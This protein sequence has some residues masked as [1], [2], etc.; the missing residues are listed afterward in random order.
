MPPRRLTLPAVATLALVSL[1]LGALAAFAD[2]RRPAAGNALAHARTALVPQRTRLVAPKAVTRA[3]RASRPSLVTT[4]APM[5]ACV[6]ATKAPAAAPVPQAILD[7]FGVL[8]RDRAATDELPADALRALRDRGLEPF[9]PAAA[10]LLRST[11]DGGRAWVVPV[12]DVGVALTRF[13]CLAGGLRQRVPSVRPVP[14]P[15]PVPAP[16]PVRPRRTTPKPKPAPPTTPSGPATAPVPVPPAVTPPSTAP[17]P[18]VPP[19]APAPSTEKREPQPGLAIVA[20]GGAPVGAG[21]TLADLV[22]GREPVALDPCAG[23]GHDMLSVSGV[24]PDGVAAAFLTGA[25]GTAV[26]ADVKD[27]G[28]AFLVPPAKRPEQRYVVWTGGDGT[29]HVQPLTWTPFSTRIRCATVPKD[30]V[31]VSP[32]SRG[33]CPVFGRR[34][35][36]PAAIPVPRTGVRPA[37]PLLIQAAPCAFAELPPTAVPVP[38]AVPPP[39]HP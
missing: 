32:Q 3:S 33:D 4:P 25:D 24:V 6:P 11:G 19:T 38:R 21:G 13:G 8:R 14:V 37:V 30:L 26:R 29:P 28:Y 10:R 39:R 27:N 15:V 31:Q 34:F 20:V 17:A 35:L 5:P 9:D 23:P 2:E 12:R 22:R 7:A 1:L 16:V 18:P 36:A